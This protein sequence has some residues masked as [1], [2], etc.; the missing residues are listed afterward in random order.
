ML[1]FSVGETVLNVAII[2][3]LVT[4]HENPNVTCITVSNYATS[5]HIQKNMYLLL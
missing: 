2:E 1:S 5:G 3:I 4:V